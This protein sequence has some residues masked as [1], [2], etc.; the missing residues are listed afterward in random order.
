MQYFEIEADEIDQIESL[1]E[2]LNLFHKERSIDFKDRFNRMTFESRKTHFL[3]KE[4]LRCFCYK[5]EQILGYC[6]VSISADTAEIESIFISPELRG[7]GVGENLMNKSLKWI[8]DHNISKVSIGVA[9]G[10]EE[11]ISFYKRFS[12]RKKCEILE[13]I[14]D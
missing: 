7:H 5:E 10:N 12:F 8:K 11:A 9:A 14:D 1:W 4:K 6:V 2:Q 13:L 3:K